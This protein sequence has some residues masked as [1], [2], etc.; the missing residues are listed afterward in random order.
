MALISAITL[1]FSRDLLFSVL[2][3]GIFGIF[4]AGAYLFMGAPDV[5]F[6]SFAL[7]ATFTTFV[8]LI[9]I[10][11]TG[12]FVVY[13]LVTPYLFFEQHPGGFS[14][15]EYEILAQFAREESQELECIPVTSPQE[16]R[17]IAKS[18]QRW[19]VLAGG[20]FLENIDW[21]SGKVQPL[22]VLPTRLYENS[23]GKVLDLVRM[24]DQVTGTNA[25]PDNALSSYLPA[26]ETDYVFLVHA[27]SRELNQKLS[28]FLNQK[29]QDGQLDEWVRRHIG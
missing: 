5:S 22:K 20:L 2:L 6:A 27:Q 9:S 3:Y 1:F 11:K 7:G 12:K 15:F 16:L 21:P 28:R 26:K 29:K 13:F 14:G 18:H 23:D 24:K 25:Q 19:D 4:S 8:F 17:K 10:R